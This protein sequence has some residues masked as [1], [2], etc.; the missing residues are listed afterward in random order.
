M[1]NTTCGPKLSAKQF[2]ERVRE[3]DELEAARTA[4]ARLSGLINMDDLSPR[5][6]EVFRTIIDIARRDLEEKNISKEEVIRRIA[7]DLQRHGEVLSPTGSVQ[8]HIAGVQGQTIQPRPLPMQQFANVQS[9]L[10]GV[11]GQGQGFPTT[12]VQSSPYPVQF[13]GYNPSPFPVNVPQWSLQQFPS[14]ATTQMPTS[15]VQ[16]QLQQQQQQQQQVFTWPWDQMGGNVD[17]VSHQV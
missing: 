9:Q 5:S 17:A 14:Q 3:E 1:T 4:T 2:R 10:G 7:R 11:Q 13:L 12:R 15:T 6:W 8:R 16:P